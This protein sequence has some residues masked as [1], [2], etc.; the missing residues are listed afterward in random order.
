MSRFGPPGRLHF[1]SS[2]EADGDL[3]VLDDHRHLA[4]ARETDHSRELVFV[5]FDVDVVD[6]VFPTRV[7]LT[8]RGRVG[9][10][11]FA[12]NLDAFEGHLTS[13]ALQ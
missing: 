9:S 13:A 4:A 8:G 10:G 1:S 2:P 3:A 5:L 7:V 6:R 11:V 12:E